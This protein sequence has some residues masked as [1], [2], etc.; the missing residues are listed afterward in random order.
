MDLPE[1]YKICIIRKEIKF[2]LYLRYNMEL[3]GN[4]SV[5]DW[6]PK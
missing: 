1:L 4:T 2:K 6:C 3:R 5:I